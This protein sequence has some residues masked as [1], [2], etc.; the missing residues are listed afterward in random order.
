MTATITTW[1]ASYFLDTLFGQRQDPPASFWVA[2]CSQAPGV[3]ADGT[4]LA[5]PDPNAGYA[6]T[7][8]GNDT[9]S[10]SA[11]NT[12]VITSAA[13]AIFPVATANWMTVT[14]YALCDSQVGGNVY[15]YA[16][17]ATPRMVLSGDIC[18]IPAGLM[19]VT[20]GSL[21]TALVSAF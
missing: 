8:L 17:L 9:Y 7:L 20:V 12:G 13:A 5:E 6:R 16:S 11:A 14:H 3:Q 21:S 19:H 15:F 1:G 4:L 10:W 2:L 18:R